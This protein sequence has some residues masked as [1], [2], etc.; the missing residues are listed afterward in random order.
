MHWS[1]IYLICAIATA[2]IF[3]K[4]AVIGDES[5]FEQNGMVGVFSIAII[6]AAFPVSWMAAVVLMGKRYY[7]MRKKKRTMESLARDC[8]IQSIREE[9]SNTRNKVHDNQ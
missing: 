5:F 8:Y 6:G 7:D 1:L 9:I 4:I 3:R 2:L